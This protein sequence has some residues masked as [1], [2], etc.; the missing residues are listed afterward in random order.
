MTDA[1]KREK[2]IKGLAECS[3][4]QCQMDCYECP[5]YTEVKG[6]HCYQELLRDALNILKE[7]EARVMPL[8]EVDKSGPY[9]VKVVCAGYCMLCGKPIETG[10]LFVC[11][12]CG[13]KMVDGADNA[14]HR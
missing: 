3:H 14:E 10:R 6:V 1:E 8:E 7:Q 12:E 4:S 5:Y 2:V 11:P 13:A 9:E